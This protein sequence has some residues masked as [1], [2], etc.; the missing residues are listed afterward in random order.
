MGKGLAHKRQHVGHLKCQRFA[1]QLIVRQIVLSRKLRLLCGENEDPHDQRQPDGLQQIQLQ[2][3]VVWDLAAFKPDVFE[4]GVQVDGV[5]AQ[6]VDQQIDLFAALVREKKNCQRPKRAREMLL[7]APRGPAGP[8]ASVKDHRIRAHCVKAGQLFAA[9]H[10]RQEN[11]QARRP[12]CK[13]DETIAFRSNG[14]TNPRDHV[15]DVAKLLQNRV[16]G[17]GPHACWVTAI[18]G[19][20]AFHL[21]FDGTRAGPKQKVRPESAKNRAIAGMS[22]QFLLVLF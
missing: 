10:H 6:M 5:E 15:S 16:V 9:R 2:A 1:E 4:D 3:V 21:T 8:E 12:F 19:A 7:P 13:L 14:R 18:G 11:F 22:E 20:G 17:N